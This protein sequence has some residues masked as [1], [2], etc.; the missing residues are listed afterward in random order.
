MDGLRCC[1]NCA[2]AGKSTWR[3]IVTCQPAGL[4]KTISGS[5]ALIDTGN[6]WQGFM[7]GRGDVDAIVVREVCLA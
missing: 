7:A 2:N 3:E 5:D 6:N 1:S 4:H